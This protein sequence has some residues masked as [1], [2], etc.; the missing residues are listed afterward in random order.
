MRCH[1]DR[2][3]RSVTAKQLDCIYKITEGI[4]QLVIVIFP[5]KIYISKTFA[6]KKKKKN[7]I[8]PKCW[9]CLL[10]LCMRYFITNIIE[11]RINN[12]I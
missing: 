4:S 12:I 9:C 6:F 5:R 3:K 1:C 2:Q 7:L 10:K 8:R 11:T